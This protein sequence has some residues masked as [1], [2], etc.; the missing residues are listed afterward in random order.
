MKT[1]LTDH[2]YH[3]LS[4]VAEGLERLRAS[5]IGRALISKGQLRP[6][7]IRVTGQG[8]A[9]MVA[10]AV[11]TLERMRLIDYMDDSVNPAGYAITSRGLM[12]FFDRGELP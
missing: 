10:R 2:E 8:A 4:A 7:R 11:S 1:H 3:V 12:V 9:L 5:D 6:S